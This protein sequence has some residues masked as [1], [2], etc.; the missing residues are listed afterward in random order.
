MRLNYL[1]VTS[2]SVNSCYYILQQNPGFGGG[3]GCGGGGGG[4]YSTTTGTGGGYTTGSGGAYTTGSGGGYTTGIGGGYSTGSG[5][6]YSTGNGGGYNTGSYNTTNYNTGGYDGGNSGGQS[7]GGQS[8]GSS[9][10]GY[11]DDSYR[12]FGDGGMEGLSAIQEEQNRLRN[13]LAMANNLL[14]QQTQLLQEVGM[15]VIGA[16]RGS[17]RRRRGIMGEMPS[18]F[19]GEMPSEFMGPAFGEKRPGSD[20]FGFGYDTKR[21]RMDKVSRF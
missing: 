14:Q 11:G 15:Q 1:I 4:G 16:N 9:T 17:R 5:G 3:Y 19:M 18:E 13:K 21:K 8:F 7:F 6:G 20:G 12:Y 10:E 2:I